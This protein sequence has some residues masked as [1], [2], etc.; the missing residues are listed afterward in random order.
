MIDLILSYMYIYDDPQNE[1]KK[2]ITKI[3][4]TQKRREKKELAKIIK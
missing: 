4:N 2:K 1:E 3:I